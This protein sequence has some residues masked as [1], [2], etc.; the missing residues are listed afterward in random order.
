MIKMIQLADRTELKCTAGELNISV[1]ASYAQKTSSRE[2]HR[3]LLHFTD[4]L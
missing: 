2:R 1:N 4:R 3:S